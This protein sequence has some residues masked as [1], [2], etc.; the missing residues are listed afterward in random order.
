MELQ[1]LDDEMV[2]EKFDYFDQIRSQKTEIKFLN[3]VID[4]LIHNE[5]L[6]KIRI[7]TQWDDTNNKFITPGFLLH[8]K[9]VTIPKVPKKK[10]KFIVS[11]M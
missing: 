6:D 10:S 1:D 9:K 5:D 7:K 4:K 2:N 11:P 8:D 3:A